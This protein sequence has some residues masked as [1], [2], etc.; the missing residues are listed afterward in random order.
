MDVLS[1][2]ALWEV[3]VMYR[4]DHPK[5]LQQE[6][7]KASQEKEKD[8]SDRSQEHSDV[9]TPAA[10]VLSIRGPRTRAASAAAAAPASTTEMEVDTPATPATPAEIRPQ[11]SSLPGPSQEAHSTQPSSSLQAPPERPAKLLDIFIEE[12]LYSSPELSMIL[13]SLLSAREFSH[14]FVGILLRHLVTLLPSLG[15]REAG[16]GQIVIRLFKLTFMTVTVYPE[17]NESVLLPHVGEIMLE[18]LKFA[19]QSSQP[20][21][22]YLLLRNLFRSIGGGRFEQIFKA[23]LP[24]L[25]PMLEQLQTLLNNSEGSTRDLFVEL[26]LTVP[27]RLSVLL[28]YLGYLMKPLKLAL[29]A[30]PEL[31]AQGLRTLELCVDN[32]THDFLNPFLQPFLDDVL[33]AL[34]KLLKPS[35]LISPPFSHQALRILGKLGGRSRSLIGRPKL[36]WRQTSPSEEA[37]LPIQF[38]HKFDRSVP[39]RPLVEL[40]VKTLRRGDE[41]YRSNAFTFLKH[42]SALFLKAPTPG[43]CEDVFGLVIG[44][45][46]DSAQAPTCGTEAGAFVV[47]YV[48]F[49]LKTDLVRQRND[50][51]SPNQLAPLT[52]LLLDSL[53][54]NLAASEGKGLTSVVELTSAIV[55]RYVDDPDLS[56]ERT[57]PV[58]QHFASRLGSL[59]YDQSRKR[60][61]GGLAGLQLLVE[62]MADPVTGNAWLQAE[63]A[64][65]IRSLLF[66]IKDSG[67]DAPPAQAQQIKDFF[68][69]VLRQSSLPLSGE[70]HEAKSRLT[71]LTSLFMMELPSQS[72]PAREAAQLALGILA[73]RLSTTPSELLMPVRNRLLL[74]IFNKP[75][76]ALAFHMQIGHIDAL[77]YLLSLSPPLVEFGEPRGGNDQANGSEPPSAQQTPQMQ[78]QQP[79]QQQQQSQS[80]SGDSA[81]GTQDGSVSS[82]QLGAGESAAQS[83]AVSPGQGNAAPPRPQQ[84]PSGQQQAGVSPFAM[85]RLLVEVIGIAD[86]EDAALVAKPNPHKSAD[87]LAQL[88]IVCIRFLSAALGTAELQSPR[89]NHTRSRILSV[90][91]KLLYKPRR[92]TV[93]AAYNC[94]KGVVSL[95]SKL[96]KDMLQAGLRFVLAPVF[97]SA[98]HHAKDPFF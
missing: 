67:S 71:F 9:P 42:A 7:N 29:A 84:Q 23:V 26:C 80:G 43:D 30:G 65:L 4:S 51:R 76:R 5:K 17:V 89:H 38:D 86:A 21:C 97:H 93:D 98:V 58:I 66:M 59:C 63:E 54:E 70:S 10:S 95:Q 37:L 46:F 47:N 82:Q 87:L 22:Y 79:P 15:S 55:A 45:L 50:G 88:R 72:A 8:E 40:A 24:L 85:T 56:A 92:D 75:L 28:P 1:F 77:T 3:E 32:L 2:S 35:P 34:W 74:P 61:M 64:T 31:M 68:A 44:G 60:K 48:V 11:P 73:E 83:P 94:L 36:K 6:A 19:S 25:H 96:P 81:S 57:T 78:H 69:L 90:N 14:C 18:S 13:Q 62:K 12:A 52:A 27:V 91:F 53:T 16:Y 39:L 41:H 20:W 49:V 33:S